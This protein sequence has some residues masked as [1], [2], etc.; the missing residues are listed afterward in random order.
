MTKTLSIMMICCVF[1]I[2]ICFGTPH[3]F[4]G[5]QMWTFDKDA[6]DWKA[7]NGTWAVQD[8]AYKVT[9]GAPA[10][11]SLVGDTSWTDYT[12][13]AKVRFDEGNWAGLVV[14][15]Q[16]D[17]EY[18]VYYLNVPDN[19]SELWRHKAGAFDARDAITS[20]IPAKN[21]AIKGGE[22]LN[23][24]VV[25]EGTTFKF[26]INNE[27]Q[28][29][30]TDNVYP[31]GQIGVWAWDTSASFDDVKVSGAG[32]PGSVTPVQPQG[33]LATRWGQIKGNY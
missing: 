29:E 7:A 8:G 3:A 23:V 19:K 11:H 9:K 32:I 5:E 31:A 15:A 20:N 22:W 4:A 13:E 33:K 25:V 26:W 14:R 12:L 24:K 27:L 30:Q 10:M 16:S 1:A 18:Y 6:S 28:G 21:V 2:G 17:M